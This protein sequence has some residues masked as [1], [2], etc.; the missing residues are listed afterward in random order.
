MRNKSLKKEDNSIGCLLMLIFLPFVLV[1]YIIIALVKG[2]K[3]IIILNGDNTSENDES[4]EIDNER[5]DNTEDEMDDLEFDEMNDI[6]DEMD[7]E[8]EF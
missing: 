2:C 1:Y 5:I 3:K 8:D 4:E 7:E 6:W